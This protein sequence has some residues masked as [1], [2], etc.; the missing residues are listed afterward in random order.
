MNPFSRNRWYGLAAAGALALTVASASASAD[1]FV[2][3]LGPV[4]PNEPILTSVGSK[5]VIA[6]YEANDA[7]CGMNILVWDRADQSGSSAA[8]VRVMLN[9]REVVHIES[10]DAKSLNLQCGE[11]AEALTIVDTSKVIAAGAAQ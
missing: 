1:D 10:A 7:G 11:S 4:G 9:P 5:Q 6:F 3:N 2:R 8:R